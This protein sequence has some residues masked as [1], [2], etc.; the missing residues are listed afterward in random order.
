MSKRRQSRHLDVTGQ[1]DVT[2][3]SAVC[4]AVENL[5]GRRYPTFN[6]EALR[7]LFRDFDRLYLGEYPG[8]LGCETGYH[9]RQHVLDVTLAVARL[10]DGH[11]ACEP[12]ERMLGAALALVGVAVALFHDAGYIRRRGDRRH[13]HGAE[14]TKTHVSRS[15]RFLAEH[16][17]KV[18]LQ[19]EAG[20]A[21]TLVH[22]TGYEFQPG[23]LKL[24]DPRH[25]MLGCLI[26]TA[27]VIA[28][29]A[30]RAYLEKCRDELYPEFE[31]GG[32]A[33]Q[34]DEQGRQRVVYASAEDL[35][36]KTPMFMRTTVSERLDGLFAGVYRYAAVHFGGRNWYM[37][38]VEA[39]CTALEA[40]LASE[41]RERLANGRLP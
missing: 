13:R 36:R 1:V 17:P 35:L 32:V 14:Y 16:L 9:D 41:D 2:D 20:L 5:L 3:A 8:F 21:S 23:N 6:R 34:V 33:R 4:V 27:D 11:D 31:L 10:I 37:E 29:M 26:G 30:D 39:N 28:Q 25:R 18:G 7:G 12:P 40:V 24:E 19:L 22:Y 15:A 38:A